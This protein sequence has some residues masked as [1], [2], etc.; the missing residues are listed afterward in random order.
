MPGKARTLLIWLGVVAAAGGHHR[1]P[2]AFGVVGEDLRR[3]V[4]AGKDDGVLVHGLHHF[5]GDGA[6]ADTPMNT[7]APTSISAR[8][9]GLRPRLVTWAISSLIQFSPPAAGVDGALAVAGCHVLD[10][11]RRAAA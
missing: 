11:R 5:R 10:A 2:P 4:G 6:G 8:V 7:S 1:G 9:P 3:G